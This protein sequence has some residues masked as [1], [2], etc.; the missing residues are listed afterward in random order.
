MLKN[1]KIWSKRKN[2][3]LDLINHRGYIIAHQEGYKQ[4]HLHQY[5]W[6]IGNQCEIPKGYQIHHINGNKTDNRLCNLE[7]IEQSKHISIHNKEHKRMLGK[8]H[9]KKTKEKLSKKVVQLT[10]TGDIV[11]VWNSFQEIGRNG[12]NHKNV[13]MCCKGIRNTHKGYMWKYYEGTK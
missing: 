11:K 4:H 7:L 8:H 10:M 12:F 2:K 9:S 13:H 3:Y 1:G 5:I 6:M